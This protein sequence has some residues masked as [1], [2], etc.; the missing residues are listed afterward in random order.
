VP[1]A[2][3]ATV[4]NN[5]L[6]IVRCPTL[7]CHRQRTPSV[8]I[9]SAYPTIRIVAKYIYIVAYSVRRVTSYK[10]VVLSGS[11]TVFVASRIKQG[12]ELRGGAL[13]AYFE[14]EMRKF[15][16]TRSPRSIARHRTPRKGRR[17][18]RCCACPIKPVAMPTIGARL[19]PRQRRRISVL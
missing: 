4:A 6:R 3:N 8:I 18:S 16:K 2:N 11:G 9:F 1:S 19:G 5:S 12:R 7:H 13:F 14:Y 15:A 10:G 17:S